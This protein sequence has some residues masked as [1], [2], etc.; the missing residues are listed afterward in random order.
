MIQQESFESLRKKVL[1]WADARNLLHE[2]NK[3]KQWGKTQEE[4]LEIYQAMLNED[5]EEVMDGIGDALV[6][7]IIL[8]DQNGMNAVN[9]LEKAYD[10]IKNRTGK[11]VNGEFVKDE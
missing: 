1:N 6:T 10:V 11:T 2:E 4:V 3:F 7:L 9:C 5:S 8:A